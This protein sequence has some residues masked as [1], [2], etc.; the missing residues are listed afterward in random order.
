[1]TIKSKAIRNLV[2]PAGDLLFGQRM[3][4]RLKFLEKAQ[5]LS[6]QELLNSQNKGL[7][8]LIRTACD[9][10]PFYRDVMLQRGILPSEILSAGDLS[11]L[12]V[13]TKNM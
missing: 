12:P 13:V 11:K 1:M 3:M 2:L 4:S 9:E 7:Q 8:S 10:V 6:Q 5:F